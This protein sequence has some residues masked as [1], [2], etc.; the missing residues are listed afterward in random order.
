MDEI[1]TFCLDRAFAEAATRRQAQKSNQ[2]KSRKND[3]PARL[4][5]HARRFFFPTH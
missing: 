1:V 4:P 2:K 3:A 5:S